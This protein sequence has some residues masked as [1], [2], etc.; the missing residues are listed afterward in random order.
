MKKLFI[1][2]MLFMIFNASCYTTFKE[3]NGISAENWQENH[4]HELQHVSGSEEC[5]RW[6]YYYRYPAW[7]KIG[8]S[9]TGYARFWNTGEYF[10]DGIY[11]IG[12]LGIDIYNIFASID[13]DDKSEK[14]IKS[15]KKLP[16]DRKEDE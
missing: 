15:D 13:N 4:N 9:K 11:F 10:I 12:S 1:S 14:Y 7:M 3:A 6:N 5:H 8:N 2:L 16:K